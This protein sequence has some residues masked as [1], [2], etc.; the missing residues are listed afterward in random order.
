MIL[1]WKNLRRKYILMAY[2]NSSKNSITGKRK[3]R[4][5]QEFVD[6]LSF[7][8]KYLNESIVGKDFKE[9]I[10]LPTE[11]EFEV[12]KIEEQIIFLNEAE[13]ESNGEFLDNNN[14][15]RQ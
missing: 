1:K 13:N 2:P 4:Y 8:D 7:L 3:I 9:E 5:N 10:Y 15:I 12:E 6:R 11:E 14:F